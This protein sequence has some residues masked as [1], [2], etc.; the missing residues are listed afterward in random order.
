MPIAIRPATP[1]DQPAI[2]ALVR[3]ARLNPIRIGWRT[4]LVAEDAGR[5]VGVGQVRPHRDGSRELASLA[6]VPDH[7]GAG[8]GTQLTWALLARETPPTYLFCQEPMAA[9]YARFGFRAIERADLPP[10]LAQ[11]HRLANLIAAVSAQL[12]GRHTRIIAMRRDG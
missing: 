6:V 4:F 8:I 2:T 10:M 7:Q 3:A 1:A 5:V 11:M 12:T 9:F